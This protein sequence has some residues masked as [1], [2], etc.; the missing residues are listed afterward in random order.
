MPK[1][2]AAFA[3]EPLQF[4]SYVGDSPTFFVPDT[5][6]AG[7][8]ATLKGPGGTVRLEGEP[9]GTPDD[10]RSDDDLA[11][12]GFKRHSNG[13]IY[14]AQ[15]L[16]QVGPRVGFALPPFAKPG[17]YVL[18]VDNDGTESVYEVTVVPRSRE[19]DVFASQFGKRDAAGNEFVRHAD[20][21]RVVKTMSGGR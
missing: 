3:D 18:T 4:L 5:G 8:T 14:S 21:N 1:P 6:A 10:G 11:A 20:F 17:D 9:A 12:A 15:T 13:R 7:A 2:R 19:G 16:E